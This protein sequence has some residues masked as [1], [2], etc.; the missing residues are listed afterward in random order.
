[1][2]KKMKDNLDAGVEKI[3]WF[4]SLLN[5]RMKVEIS[6]FRLL[7]RSAELEKKRTALMTAV[8][9][10]VFQL[11][12]TPDR[13]VLRDPAIA[14]ALKTLEE[15]NAELEDTRKKAAEIEKIEA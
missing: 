12:G 10:R 11:K 5:E 15:L 2:W 9:E 4:S 13:Q 1:M 6:V 7:Y 14:D 8:G 3:R